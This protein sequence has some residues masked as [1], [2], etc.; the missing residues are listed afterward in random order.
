MSWCIIRRGSRLNMLCVISGAN[1]NNGSN[2]GPW[3]VNL[4]NNRTNSNNNVGFASDSNPHLKH[5]SHGATGV[6]GGGFQPQ[7]KPCHTS[8]SGSYCER[9]RGAQ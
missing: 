7:A 5:P 3:A 2:A 8:L 6:E 1:W 9:Q 4:N